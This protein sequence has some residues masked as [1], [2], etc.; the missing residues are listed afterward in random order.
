[1]LF[2]DITD[3]PRADHTRHTRLDDDVFQPA[4][5]YSHQGHGYCSDR[6]GQEGSYGRHR[7][8][9]SRWGRRDDDSYQSRGGWNRYD[10]ES[11]CSSRWSRL[12]D[13][14]YQPA[15]VNRYS[16]DVSQP[17]AVEMDTPSSTSYSRPYQQE[18][19]VEERRSGRRHNALPSNHRGHEE[20][21]EERMRHSH[22]WCGGAL[23]GKPYAPNTQSQS[24]YH[25]KLPHYQS[26]NG[27]S[28]G[29]PVCDAAG[30]RHAHSWPVVLPHHRD[31]QQQQQCADI[32][33]G[34]HALAS[35]SHTAMS[36]SPYYWN[37]WSEQ[38]EEGLEGAELEGGVATHTPTWDCTD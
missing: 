13:D 29:Q 15:A 25:Q 38:D 9:Y 17:A 3:D 20:G 30:M 16:D 18:C 23:Y 32:D 14:V 10:N 4:A 5:D 26:S 1:M 8:N 21:G 37:N 22:S 6:W 12:D 34:A 19:R 33:T 2:S 28:S 11:N 35:T 24:L 27:S 31:N 36:P 7:S